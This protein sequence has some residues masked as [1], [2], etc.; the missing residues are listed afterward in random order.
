LGKQADIKIPV[1]VN[2]VRVLL[3]SS[4]QSV[5]LLT[6]ERGKSTPFS[7]H[8]ITNVPLDMPVEQYLSTLRFENRGK[9][10]DLGLD[11][12]TNPFKPGD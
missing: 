9:L 1:W 4:P 12:D 11:I 5:A 2:M 6:G 8:L 3:G 10:D 7:T